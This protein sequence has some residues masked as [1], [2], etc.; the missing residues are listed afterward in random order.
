M[1]VVLAL[2]PAAAV[3]QTW[4]QWNHIDS[5]KQ[6]AEQLYNIAQYYYNENVAPVQREFNAI[7]DDVSPEKLQ[8][9][10]QQLAADRL[11]LQQLTDAYN[12]NNQQLTEHVTALLSSRCNPQAIAV[13]KDYD[14]PSL[15]SS[16]ALL[17]GYESYC[18]GL[19]AP[20]LAVKG[21]LERGGWRKL[22][23][24]SAALQAFD[25][26]WDNAPYVNF[27]ASTSGS[28]IP[29]L[30]DC[31]QQVI[32]LRFQGFDN[33]RSQLEQLLERLTPLSTASPA[34]VGATVAQQRS[35][36]NR[37]ALLR[38]S[39]NDI[40]AQL[41]TISDINAQ[42]NELGQQRY[43]VVER[44]YDRREDLDKVLIA[45]ARYCLSYP[46]DSVGAYK[47]M[48]AQVRP[49]LDSVFH[50]SY[51]A[52]RDRY[53]VLLADYDRHTTQLGSFLKKTLLYTKTGSIT[54]E[55]RNMITTS[56]Q[57]LDYY[58]N[59]Y[60]RRNEAKPVS[61]PYLDGI[62]A[63]FEQMLASGFAGGKDQIQTLSENL[64]GD[65]S[66]YVKL[67][68]DAEDRKWLKKNET[69][70]VKGV[71]FTMI[72]VRGGTFTMGA[73]PE[74]GGDADSDEKPVHRVTLSSF[75]IGQT[76][77]TQEL[78]QAVMGNNPSN[79]KGAKL[80]VKEVSWDDCQ[81]FIKK[82]NALTGK[83]FRLPTEAE[84]EYAARGGVKSQGY[85]YSGSD[86]LDDVA[87]YGDNSG[88][89]THAV[90]T[91]RPNELGLYDM[92]GNVKEWCQDWY[93]DYSS[94]AQTN[95]QGPTSGYYRVIRGGGWGVD[96]RYCH[97]AD[98]GRNF[99]GDRNGSLG[100]RLAL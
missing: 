11:Q 60:S 49:M 82:L 33:C 3:A 45:A 61:S 42:Y 63:G 69:F 72:A 59:Y 47:W 57:S 97:V 95:P 44:W 32:A 52:Q 99:A 62:I 46:C 20:L 22:D 78:W 50:K 83:R 41:G 27:L 87:W 86:N 9:M 21:V 66:Y 5:V 37:M 35:N 93:G 15:R 91:K 73:T 75:M 23:E 30:D 54:A 36:S 71:T 79:F 74:Q 29:F 98:R 56:L 7:P 81:E 85:K 10:K 25:K 1:T 77:V 14:E 53:L 84:W 92:S 68:E 8:S 34:D 100:F 2:W 80:P 89:K 39:I 58:Q 38:R 13:V 4:E 88:S 96:A 19:K 17:N 43:E 64:R 40:E 48:A 18:Q 90:A 24:N 76:E 12:K 67:E 31:V 55:T 28:G 94:S 65:Y 70:K 26:A 6:H 51:R 16:I